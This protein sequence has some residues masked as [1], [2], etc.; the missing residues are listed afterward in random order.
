MNLLVCP[1]QATTSNAPQQHQIFD[2]GRLCE[3]ESTIVN[4]SSGAEHCMKAPVAF[5]LKPPQPALHFSCLLGCKTYPRCRTQ[6]EGPRRRNRRCTFHASFDA[7]LILDAVALKNKQSHSERKPPH[8]PPMVDSQTA[9]AQRTIEQKQNHHYYS[10][11]VAFNEPPRADALD[12]IILSRLWWVFE[13]DFV[14][15]TLPVAC[16]VAAAGVCLPNVW[17]RRVDALAACRLFFCVLLA[18]VR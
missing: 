2:D 14:G 17:P 9:I 6:H 3:S 13:L 12:P 16:R 18:Y 11:S 10:K 7:T 1:N 4:L 8:P 15:M 5:H